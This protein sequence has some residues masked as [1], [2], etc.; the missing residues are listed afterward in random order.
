MSWRNIFFSEQILA[1]LKW[2]I[3]REKLFALFKVG[4]HFEVSGYKKPTMKEV[5]KPKERK[6][7]QLKLS[8]QH[9]PRRWN[10]KHAENSIVCKVSSIFLRQQFE[11]SF[12]KLIEAK[13]MVL[14]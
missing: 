7:F 10:A 4:E 14:N 1:K 3:S 12:Q 5:K 2:I 13:R 8:K 11:E 9:I 6:L